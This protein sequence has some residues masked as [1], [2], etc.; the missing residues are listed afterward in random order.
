MPYERQP[1]LPRIV[2]ERIEGTDALDRI[3]KGKRALLEQLR[4]LVAV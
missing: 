4:T 3:H 1:G 2:V